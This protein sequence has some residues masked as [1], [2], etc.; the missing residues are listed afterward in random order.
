[1]RTRQENLVRSVN[2]A[3][4]KYGLPSGKKLN[5]NDVLEK[6]LEQDNHLRMFYDGVE[7]HVEWI[8]ET[9]FNDE[10]APVCEFLGISWRYGRNE[11]ALQHA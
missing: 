10:Y 6:L 9:L 4:R 2:K 11:N 8:D 7:N 1:M 5:A 3:A